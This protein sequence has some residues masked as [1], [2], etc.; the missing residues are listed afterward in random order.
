MGNH[1]PESNAPATYIL[2]GGDQ[3]AAR[4]RILGRATWPTTLELLVGAGIAPG[5]RVLDLGCGSGEVTVELAG[6]VGAS[7]SVTG[8]DTDPAMLEVARAR[9]LELDVPID[10]VRGDALGPYPADG[11][12][13]VYAR[14]LLSHLA[15]PAAALGAMRAATRR[16][17]IV[18][19]EDVDFPGHLWH[20]P[21]AAFARYV[22]LYQEVARRRGGDAAIGPQLPRLV[23]QAGY[24]NVQLDVVQPT[25]LDGDGKRIAVLT[26]E[27]IRDAVVAAGLAT[28]VEVDAIVAELDAH[29]RDPSTLQSIARIVQ[30]WATRRD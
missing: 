15:D 14:F 26:M 8:V 5:M 24:A 7:G 1:L 28:H 9:T 20:P 29:R 18:I 11:Y 10:F 3:G 4:L 2:T 27:A 13:A 16:G 6:M 30:V 17:G 12:D 25:F 19:V 21:C 22:E 23:H